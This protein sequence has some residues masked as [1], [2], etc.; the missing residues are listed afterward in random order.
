M[1]MR[2][3][4]PIHRTFS[5]RTSSYEQPS[6]IFDSNWTSTESEPRETT[7]NNRIIFPTKMT[8]AT[9]EN[10]GKDQDSR[11][12]WNSS[13]VAGVSYLIPKARR[14]SLWRRSNNS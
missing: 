2:F 11:R 13:K 5:M 9:D 4:L 10:D 12:R 14:H 3:H 1:V 7:W 8:A 6:R